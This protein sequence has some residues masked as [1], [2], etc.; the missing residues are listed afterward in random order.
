MS[1]GSL[2]QVCETETADHACRQ[3]GRQV[4]ERHYDRTDAACTVCA[5]GSGDSDG[6]GPGMGGGPDVVR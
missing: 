6:I 5:T 4:C 2:C 3:C 1:V